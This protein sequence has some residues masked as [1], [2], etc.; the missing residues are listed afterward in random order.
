[1]KKIKA[2]FFDVDG[3]LYSHR[4]HE[5]P[6]STIKTLNR[7]KEKGYKIG[8]ATSRCRYEMENLPSFFRDFDFDAKI[9]D[10]GALVMVD[11]QVLVEHPM[12]PVDMKKIVDFTK[13]RGLALRYS[14]FDNDYIAHHCNADVLDRFFKLYLNMP[15]VK[16]YEDTDKVYNLIVYNEKEEQISELEQ[17]LSNSSIIVHTSF[18]LELTR[19]GIEKSKGIQAILNQW[20]LSFDEVAC[21]GDGANDEAMVKACGLGV[22]M[23]NGHI[24]VKEAADEICGHVDEDGIYRFCKEKGFLD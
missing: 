4:L 9:I 15:N 14:T 6:Q 18:A 12:D 17:L 10:G 11:D 5:F 22:A 19:K 24:K 7:L 23:G 1:M 3:T 13:E 8:I 2:F 16:E 20:G 21:F